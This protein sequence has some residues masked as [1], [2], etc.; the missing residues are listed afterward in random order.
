MSLYV[1]M[2]MRGDT[3]YVTQ[4]K[5]EIPHIIELMVVIFECCVNKEYETQWGNVDNQGDNDRNQQTV[6]PES[7]ETKENHYSQPQ[8]CPQRKS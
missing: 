7:T 4:P 8:S 2:S 6:I 1:Y 3:S 5:I